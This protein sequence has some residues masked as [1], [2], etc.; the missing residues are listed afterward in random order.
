MQ[1]RFVRQKPSNFQPRPPGLRMGAASSSAEKG[2]RRAF[3]TAA[4]A[5]SAASRRAFPRG[6]GASIKEAEVAGA[7]GAAPPGRGVPKHLQASAL[8]QA[9]ELDGRELARSDIDGAQMPR[10]TTENQ[11][12]G[13][14]VF[15]LDSLSEIVQPGLSIE[16]S[17]RADTLASGKQAMYAEKLREQFEA[18]VGSDT[19]GE[20]NLNSWLDELGA[21]ST[22]TVAAGTEFK[23]KTA[24]A[25]FSGVGIDVL[26]DILH[27]ADAVAVQ[28]GDPFQLP[29][30]D[31]VRT[32]SDIYDLDPVTL[33][34]L[35][36]FHAIP[37]YVNEGSRLKSG[38]AAESDIG[39]GDNA[40]GM[41]SGQQWRG[42]WPHHL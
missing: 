36:R 20:K 3:P 41:Q 4:S 7:D 42:Y 31:A 22:T 15:D 16:G 18:E 9:G 23:K 38:G 25:P 32:V 13:D 2:A 6:R 1:H 19:A 30:D 39:G 21:I 10:S 17:T 33:N 24:L 27:D 14:S 5:A 40:K 28:D 11:A 26:N 12:E 29:L 34:Q 37:A 8:M 35:L